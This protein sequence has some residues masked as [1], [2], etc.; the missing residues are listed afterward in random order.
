MI[1]VLAMRRIAIAA[2]LLLMGLGLAALALTASGST[3]DVSADWVPAAGISFRLTA[4]PVSAALLALNGL[5]SALAFLAFTPR[6]VSSPRLYMVLLLIA[7]AAAAGVLL[8]RDLVLFFV[9]WEAALLPF[10]LLIA[11]FGEGRRQYIAFKLL[12][13][14]SLGSL[15]MLLGIVTLYLSQPASASFAFAA[16]RHAFVSNQPVAL[17]L[18][19]ADYVFIAFALAFAIKTPLFPLHG[20]LG[21]AYTSAP[22]PGVMVLAGVISKLGPY[23]FFRV[24]LG[25]LPASA[26]RFSPVLMGLAAA[27]VVYGAL[28]ALRQVDIKRTVAYLS[29]SHMCFITLGI[30]GLTAA[31]VS[32]GLLQTLNHGILIAGLFFIAGTIERATGTRLISKLGGLARGAPGLAAVFL[33]I[34][35]GV[36]GLPGLNGFVGEYL[37]MLGTF[38]R[39]SWALALAALGVVLAAWY[40]L[41]LY[42]GTMNGA[43]GTMHAADPG[44]IGIAVLGPVAALTVFIGVFPAPLLSAI[45]HSVSAVI[46]SLGG[47]T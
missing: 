26:Q 20:W 45:G 6:D 30:V 11:V 31:G 37:I 46:N 28:L 40:A 23:G 35:L 16:V 21:D 24:G 27:G 17:G 38:A 12:I 33:L 13:Y 32:G 14:S 22:T 7:E 5:V 3:I 15:A 34:T 44:A 41:R 29:L 19:P 25:L 42:Q 8:A 39:A 10:F 47:G 43:D 9:S 1:P 18:S 4:D 2:S 36:L